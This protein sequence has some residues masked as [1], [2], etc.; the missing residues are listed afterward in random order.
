LEHML[1]MTTGMDR[2]D[3]LD[4]GTTGSEVVAT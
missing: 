1:H 2:H 3:G 4:P